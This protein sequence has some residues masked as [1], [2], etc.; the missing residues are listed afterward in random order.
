MGRE[1][2]IYYD[3]PVLLKNEELYLRELVKLSAVSV[4]DYFNMLTEFLSLEPNAQRALT[5]F[6]NRDAD[7]ESYRGLNDMAT[8]LE[9]LG[10]ENF[11][12][13]FYTILDAYEKGNWRLASHHANKISE[14]FHNLCL[15]I[16][17][18]RRFEATVHPS[19]MDT[20]MKNLINHLDDKEADRKPVILAVDDSPV[21]LKSVSSVLSGEYKVFTLPK[22]AEL[23]KVLQ[24]ITPDLFLLDY[25]MPDIN[26]FELIPIIRGFKEH[27][28]TPIIFLTSIGTIDNVTAAIALG[29]SDF[30]VKPFNPESLA[31]KVS[32]HIIKKN[33]LNR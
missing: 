2:I 31:E 32:R 8:I 25:L 28:E 33:H 15:E 13:E 19:D 30:I 9:K 18:A 20:S 27:K 10:C 29:A 16:S 26:G 3:V 14:S 1:N 5:Q 11:I 17:E 12:P 6:A 24:Q 22:P 4:R 21:L 23:Q 7:R